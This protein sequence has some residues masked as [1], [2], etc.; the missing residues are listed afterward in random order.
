MNF[1]N[2][3]GPQLV[4]AWNEM[5]LTASDLGIEVQAVKKFSDQAT[6]RKRCEMLD[7]QIQEKWQQPKS[8]C[9]ID[10][11]A[12]GGIPKEL[13]RACNPVKPSS[14]EKLLEVVVTSDDL[15]V[16]RSGL[17]AS[18]SDE[19]AREILAGRE[20]QKKAKQ[21]ERIAKLKEAQAAKEAKL[22][23]QANT[24]RAEQGLELL[25]TLKPIKTKKEKD[26][27]TKSKT[28]SNGA[29]KWMPNDWKI[30]KLVDDPEKRKGTRSYRV[31]EKYR[32]G[33][34]VAAFKEATQREQNPMAYL[35][36]DI[37]HGFVKVSK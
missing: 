29:G 19:E 15:K 12:E 5:V 13:C 3:N 25:T 8:G 16:W 32:N 1:E 14:P 2:M 36:W 33:M 30:T 34:T 20:A 6:G 23:E 11:S 9:K 31:W 10:H 22:L 17:P 27:A 21:A 18:L 24:K 26:M 4:A 7:K 35:R 37:E 28:K